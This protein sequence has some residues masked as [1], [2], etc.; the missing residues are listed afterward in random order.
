MTK[1]NLGGKGLFYLTACNSSSRNIWAGIWS[2]ELMQRNGKCRPLDCSYGLLS[3]SFFIT[4][5]TT[6][7]EVAP[8]TMDSV[9][10]HCHW[11]SNVLQTACLLVFVVSNLYWYFNYSELI[12]VSSIKILL[13]PSTYS[14]PVS[15]SRPYWRDSFHL[16]TSKVLGGWHWSM[17]LSVWRQHSVFI[18]QTS[19]FETNEH[20]IASFVL[21]VQKQN[22]S[23]PFGTPYK[24][25]YC[26]S[27]V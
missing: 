1:S 22:N 15:Q 11:F 5:R 24:F 8:P 14:S 20:E 21:F 19:Y 25:W 18:T 26:F 7:P 2:Q 4:P 12:F 6:S 10:P 9:L 27:Y 13:H 17:C 23:G 16:T 3:L